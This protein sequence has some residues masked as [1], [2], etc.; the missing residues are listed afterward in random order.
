[1]KNNIYLPFKYYIISILASLVCC[2]ARIHGFAVGILANNT[3]E[4][5]GVLFS[6]SANKGTQFIQLC[7]TSNT[8][9]LFLQNITGFMVGKRAEQ[10]GI[11]KAGARLINAISNSEGLIFCCF[12]CLL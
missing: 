1:L 10:Q 7:N 4:N 11:I 9:L 3:M 2:W 8:P 5:S 12:F 6:E